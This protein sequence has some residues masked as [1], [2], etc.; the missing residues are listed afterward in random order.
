[1][2]PV[3]AEDRHPFEI[4]AE[5]QL[6]IDFLPPT[7]LPTRLSPLSPGK[8][9]ETTVTYDDEAIFVYNAPLDFILILFNNIN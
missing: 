2:I 5:I 9:G 6:Q 1:M 4:F 3:L 8:K 7:P